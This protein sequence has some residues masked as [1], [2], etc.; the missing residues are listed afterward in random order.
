VT[1]SESAFM[2]FTF[3]ENNQKFMIPIVSNKYFVN[4]KNNYAEIKSSQVYKN[5]FKKPLEI[6]YSIPTD[7]LFCITRVV[8]VY[9]NVTVEGV[10]KEKEKAKA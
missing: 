9:D 8:A 10:V 2:C 5:P 1:P 7:P 3:L 6:H 4:I